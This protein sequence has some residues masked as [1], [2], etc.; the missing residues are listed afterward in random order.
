MSEARSPASAT[1]SSR[2]SASTSPITVIMPTNTCATRARAGC[3]AMCANTPSP[4]RVNSTAV[5]PNATSCTMTKP[6][7]SRRPA[8]TVI[9]ITVNASGRLW[10]RPNTA[11]YDA[12]DS[13]VT[14]AYSARVRPGS[15]AQRARSGTRAPPRRPK[16][17]YSMYPRRMPA[18]PISRTLTV[19]RV[20]HTAA[21][22]H[23]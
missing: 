4:C 23:E 18:A 12:A 9:A 13:A 2:P 14:A 8:H 6:V 21:A 20:S 17:A 22:G 19:L 5:E 3:E 15:A 7:C 10:S 16:W 11:A 1:R